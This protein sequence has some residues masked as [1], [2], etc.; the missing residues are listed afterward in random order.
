MIYKTQYEKKTEEL[1][2]IK[3]E[4]TP[5]LLL[6]TGYGGRVDCSDLEKRCKTLSNITIFEAIEQE[7]GG[8]D[9][10]E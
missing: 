2:K 7:L 5:T 8:S 4:N 1:E 10:N 3:K 9:D 6:H